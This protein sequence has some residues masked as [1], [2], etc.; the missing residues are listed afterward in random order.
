MADPTPRPL[1]LVLE[2]EPEEATP[3]AEALAFEGYLYVM[4]RSDDRARAE[5]AR[6]DQTIAALVAD[7]NLSAPEGRAFMI[8]TRAKPRYSALPIIITSGNSAAEAIELAHSLD[9]TEY[10]IKPYA[11]TDLLRLVAH[12]TRNEA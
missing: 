9:N 2:N 6:E 4:A 8:E 7:L 12:W 3:I 5:L 10:L 11:L 1:I